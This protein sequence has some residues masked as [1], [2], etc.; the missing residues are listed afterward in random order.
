MPNCNMSRSTNTTTATT[1]DRKENWTG[2]NNSLAWEMKRQLS[3]AN[4]LNAVIKLTKVEIFPPVKTVCSANT[5]QHALW[6]YDP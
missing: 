5:S 3:F 1:P 2:I 4:T 6:T